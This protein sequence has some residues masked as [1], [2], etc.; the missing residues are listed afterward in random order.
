MA[1]LPWSCQNP[2]SIYLLIYFWDRVSLCNPGWP[3]T[4]NAPVHLSNAGITVMNHHT[5]FQI[6][7]ILLLFHPQDAACT[8]GPKMVLYHYHSPTHSEGRKV[9]KM[10]CPSP[11][12][13]D[14]SCTNHFFPNLVKQNVSRMATVNWKGPWEILSTLFMQIKVLLLWKRKNEYWGTTYRCSQHCINWSQLH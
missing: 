14:S 12:L 7:F 2:E 4:C 8:Q 1:G 6:I 13:Q 9:K 3:R 5:Q 10:A 11:N